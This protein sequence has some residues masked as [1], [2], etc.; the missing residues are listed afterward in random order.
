M[1]NGRSKLARRCFFFDSE[2]CHK[3]EADCAHADVD[4]LVV[5][6]ESAGGGEVA[7]EVPR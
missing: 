5:S 7:A 1:E 6:L 2:K 3:R 4:T